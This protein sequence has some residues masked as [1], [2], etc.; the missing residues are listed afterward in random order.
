MAGLIIKSKKKF[1]SP[2]F[3]LPAPPIK[4]TNEESISFSV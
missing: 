2:L 4:S 3:T 1:R